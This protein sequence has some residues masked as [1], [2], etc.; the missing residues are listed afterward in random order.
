MHIAVAL[1]TPVV[2][3]FGVINALDCSG[4]WGPWGEGHIAIEARFHC[5][6]CHP[7]DCKTLECMESISVED[8]LEAARKQLNRKR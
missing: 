6:E 2:T 7:S 1:K 4:T 3:L 5:P 8:V